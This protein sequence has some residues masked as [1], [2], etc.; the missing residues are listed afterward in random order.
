MSG[1]DSPAAVIE[2]ELKLHDHDQKAQ[3][4]RSIS[5]EKEKGRLHYV[6]QVPF[7]RLLPL[8]RNPIF[9]GTMFELMAEMKNS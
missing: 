8:F 4:M 5:K 6:P 3:N 9:V 1:R 7:L 2:L